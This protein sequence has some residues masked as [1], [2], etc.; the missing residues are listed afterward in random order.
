MPKKGSRH[1]LVL[2]TYL[3]NRWWR[4][5]FSIGIFL[6]IFAA[7]LY[8]LPVLAPRYP[9]ISVPANS[10]VILFWAAVFAFLFAFFFIIIRKFAY[11]RAYENHLRLVTP[12]LQ[13]KISYRRIRQTSTMAFSS[14]FPLEKFRGRQREIIYPLMKRTLVVLDLNGFPLPRSLLRLFL[15]RFFFPDD[16]SRLALLVP[17]WI[18]FSTELESMRGVWNESIKKTE[19]DPNQAILN[20]ISG[21]R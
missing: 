7:G 13:V 18:N 11:V 14:F 6:A 15:S 8:Y 5:I 19:I 12:F 10:V 20:S 21:R 16:T 9:P 1:H 17:D 2:Y 3:L 4:R